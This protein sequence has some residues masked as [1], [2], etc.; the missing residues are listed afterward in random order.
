MTLRCL[1]V[2][3]NAD[4]ADAAKDLLGRQGIAVLAVAS[5]GSEA[6]RKVAELRPDVVL[7][8]VN[9][10]EES[11]FDVV[12]ALADHGRPLAPRVI[13]ISTHDEQEFADRIAESPAAGFV[14]KT[15]LSADRIRA[16]I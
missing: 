6:E 5:S 12:R 7:V 4:F 3:D 14:S 13:L 2:D 1:I 10:G 11:G 9:L 15:E 8:D 16:L